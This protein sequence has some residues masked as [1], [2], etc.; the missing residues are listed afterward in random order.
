MLL[1]KE[2]L[3]KELNYGYVQYV[4]TKEKRKIVLNPFS[5]IEIKNN[6][7]DMKKLLES[8]EVP[9]ILENKNKCNACNLREQC[10]GFN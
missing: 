9:P 4:N 8:K 2:N 7:E 1:A 10:Y 5:E 3:G 6:V